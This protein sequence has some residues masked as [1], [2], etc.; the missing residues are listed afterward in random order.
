MFT[1]ILNNR[2]VKWAEN[3]NLQKEEQAGYR[4]KYSTIDLIFRLQALCQKY[5]IKKEGRFYALFI[6]FTKAFETIHHHLVWYEVIKAG[7]KAKI[8]KR[9]KL[10][11]CKFKILC[12]DTVRILTKYFQCTV[13]T[14]QGYMLS[15]FFSLYMYTRE[16]VGMMKNE[17][18]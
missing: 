10:Y 5:I 15:P 1:K 12:K 8:A 17:G 3:H 14:R 16:L 2:L 4:K 18:F 9:F 7:V 6:E 11:V 13:S